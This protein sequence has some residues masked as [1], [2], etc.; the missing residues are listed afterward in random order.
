MWVGTSSW[1]TFADAS[2]SILILDRILIECVEL[3]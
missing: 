3:H 1:Q 2:K